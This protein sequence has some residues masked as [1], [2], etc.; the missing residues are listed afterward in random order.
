MPTFVGMTGLVTPVGQLQRRLGIRKLATGAVGVCTVPNVT[1]WVRPASGPADIRLRHK[2]GPSPIDYA[3]FT[4]IF[5]DCADAAIV[6]GSVTV[7]T[8]LAKLASILSRSTP[9]GRLKLR[10][11]AP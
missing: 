6:F 11:N 3:A 2:G 5:F 4:S 1:P 8:P 9:S 10:W 7:S